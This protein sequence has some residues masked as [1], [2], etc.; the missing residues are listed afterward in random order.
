MPDQLYGRQRAEF[1]V[2]LQVAD[3]KWTDAEVIVDLNMPPR[4][5]TTTTSESTTTW[6]NT[7][8]TEG[9][10]GSK[11]DAKAEELTTEELPELTTVNGTGEA[12][13]IEIAES[14]DQVT[15]FF[16]IN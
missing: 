13:R 15:S 10:Q 11:I 6:S 3:E 9:S 1:R 12:G 4:P 8:S 16:S 7:S 2:Q 14:S 5:T